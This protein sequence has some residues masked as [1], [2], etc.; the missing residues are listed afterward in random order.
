[1]CLC[2]LPLFSFRLVFPELL[3]WCWYVCLEWPCFSF[4]L[5]LIMRA[6]FF[7]PSSVVIVV[8]SFCS[9]AGWFDIS[10]IPPRLSLLSFRFLCILLMFFVFVSLASRRDVRQWLHR[11][12][13]WNAMPTL[14][15]SRVSRCRHLYEWVSLHL[16][17]I[18][19]PAHYV[20]LPLLSS[21]VFTLSLLCLES[22]GMHVPQC[23][24]VRVLE[25]WCMLTSQILYGWTFYA[26]ACFFLRCAYACVCVCV[27]LQAYHGYLLFSDFF[28][29]WSFSHASYFASFSLLYF[30]FSVVR[31]WFY[32]LRVPLRSLPLFLAIRASCLFPCRGVGM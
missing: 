31:S 32:S 24:C 20:F 1:M 4:S 11:F 21:I 2:V 7:S 19:P 27:W 12:L 25:P 15:A 17:V 14:I 3:C 16:H 5:S 10:I 26:F 6:S 18:C 23:V 22:F 13:Q 28:S 29:C 8:K 9:F 30:F